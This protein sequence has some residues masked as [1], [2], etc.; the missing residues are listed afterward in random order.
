MEIR[1]K[2]K[3]S[4]ESIFTLH[5]LFFVSDALTVLMPV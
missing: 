1:V 2:M 3:K 5:V 4:E